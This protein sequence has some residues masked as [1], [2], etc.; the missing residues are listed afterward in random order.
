MKDYVIGLDLGGTNIRAAAVNREGE[1]LHR[2]KIPTEVPLGRERVIANILKVIDTIKKEHKGL[3]L[4]AVGMGIPGVIF[5]D[6]GI[7]ARSPNFPDWIDFNLRERLNKYLN[8]PFYIDNDANLAAVGEGWLGAGKKFNSFCMLT[9]G[10]GVGGGIVLNKNI[11]R[12]EYGMAGELGHITIYPDGHPC[13]CG[14]RGCLEQYASAT[15]IVRMAME[16]NPPSP[17]FTKGGKEG[18][19]T[20][21]K[22]YQL[23]KNGDRYSLEIFQKMGRILGI[24]IADLVNI[25]NIELFVLGG[26]VADSWNYFIDSAIDEIKKRTYRITG[27]RVKVV[28]AELGDDAG[29][30]GAAYM[31]MK[32]E[33]SNSR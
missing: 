17:P 27:E 15:G 19:I 29:I 7:V 13:N 18:G 25:L 2:V 4:S 21:D 12:G 10:T 23:A 33:I 11:W 3:K 8:V 28:K 26:G 16:E 22:I 6:K 9:L 31:A 30:F 14:N 1:I 5:F 20:A 32:E 24:G